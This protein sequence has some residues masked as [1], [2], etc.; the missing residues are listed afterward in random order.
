[1]G[2]VSSFAARRAR[3]GKPPWRPSPA[4]PWPPPARFRGCR[5]PWP[6]RCRTAPVQG[7]RGRPAWTPRTGRPDRFRDVLRK[8][9][10][11]RFNAA[12]LDSAPGLVELAGDTVAIDGKTLR[13]AFGEDGR[14]PCVVSAFSGKHQ[15]VIAQVKADEKSNETAA[16][17]ALLEMLL[18]E[19]C[20]VSID[21]AGCQKDTSRRS[22]SAMATTSSRSRATCR[23]GADARGDPLPLGRRGD[24]LGAGHGVRRGPL[25]GAQRPLD[26]EPGPAA[27]SGD[28]RT[29]R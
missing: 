9:D 28:Q 26:R 7:T 10:P 2:T 1:M 12:L 18:P 6:R 8:L 4:L 21:A 23:P 20:I 3:R 24:A 27:A 13:R 14:R 29:A 5:V 22:S 19:G 11:R 25:A 15:I 16:V 17:P